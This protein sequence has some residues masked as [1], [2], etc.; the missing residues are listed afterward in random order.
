MQ[1]VHILKQRTT[2]NDVK[3]FVRK[4]MKSTGNARYRKQQISIY[5]KAARAI[6]AELGQKLGECAE[7]NAALDY[8]EFQ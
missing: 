2:D 3:L 5:M 4:Y 6:V 7:L 1:P 8:L